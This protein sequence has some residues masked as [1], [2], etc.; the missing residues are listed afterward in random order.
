MGSRVAIPAR[1]LRDPGHFLALGFGSGLV[2]FAP[3]TA[4]TV[5]AIPVFLLLQSLGWTVYMAVTVVL[6]VLGI[7][8][9]GRTAKT[10]AV[11]DHPGIVWDEVVGYLVTMVLVPATPVLII[12]GFVFFRLFDIW[13]PWPIRKLDAGVGGGL[14]IMLD[15]ILAGVYAAAFVQTIMAVQILPSQFLQ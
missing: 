3:G 14:G 4:G 12:T 6:F 8:L 10:L 2:P 11:H 7:Y 15:D 13:K 9:C 1:L 5:A